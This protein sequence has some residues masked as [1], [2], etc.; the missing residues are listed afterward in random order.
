LASGCA[1]RFP[2]TIAYF[3]LVMQFI[4]IPLKQGKE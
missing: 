2:S 3:W 1:P 4:P